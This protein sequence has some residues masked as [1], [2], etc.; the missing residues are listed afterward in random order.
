VA[1]TL[2]LLASVTDGQ[3]KGVVIVLFCGAA[4]LGIQH[5][6]YV[7]FGTVGRVL[8]DGAVRRHLAAQ[9]TLRNFET[10]VQDVHT[11]RDCWDALCQAAEKFGYGHV[12]AK[13][14]GEKYSTDLAPLFEAPAAAASW[15]VR[16]PLSG[17][18]YV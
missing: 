4:W 18:D 7:E 3:F 12:T 16:I 17:G 14:C 2:S 13:L 5:L 1:A 11:P 10:A 15:S 6:G 9:I 8:S